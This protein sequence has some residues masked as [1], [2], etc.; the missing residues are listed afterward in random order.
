[1]TERDEGHSTKPLRYKDCLA[2][3]A[4]ALENYVGHWSVASLGK[5]C[6]IVSSLSL[7]TVLDQLQGRNSGKLTELM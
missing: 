5:D 2:S 6:I 3:E 7:I 4:K 1:M